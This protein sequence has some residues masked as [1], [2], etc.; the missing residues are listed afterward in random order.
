[1]EIS[2]I[3]SL[4][5]GIK[6]G[7]G[8]LEKIKDHPRRLIAVTG[9]TAKTKLPPGEGGQAE[10]DANGKP[11][12]LERTL[13]ERA[14]RGEMYRIIKRILKKRSSAATDDEGKIWN[15]RFH[16]AVEI[17]RKLRGNLD[18]LNRQYYN[19]EYMQLVG[20]EVLGEQVGIPVRR[21]SLRDKNAAADKDPTP[22]FIIGGATSGTTVTKGTAET[23][24]LQYPDR[25]VY[26][27]GYPDSKQSAITADLPEKLKEHGDLA[28]YTQINK[29]VLLRM[30]FEKFDLVGLSMGGGI[31][32]QAATDPEF[33]KKIN[34]LIAISPTSIQET[35]GKK[36]LGIDFARETFYLRRHPTQ[37]LRV[38]QVQPGSV[39]GN[40]KDMGLG[41]TGEISRHK[42]LSADDLAN[43]HIQGRV[44]I[45]TGEKDLVISC[46]QT[47][48]ETKAANENRIKKGERPIEFMEV[49]GARHGLGVVWAP[50]IAALIKNNEVLPGQVSVSQLENSTAKVL[51]RE[52]PQLAVVA[53]QILP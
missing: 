16:A 48:R 41:I 3:K 32:L 52:N 46:E 17:S 9:M 37:W 43:L 5:K 7:I 47:K 28:T 40:H 8:K 38:P 21:Y 10:Q 42:T 12:N 23:F 36:E 25:D 22:I 24:A 26:V 44:I 45:G 18:M 27:I 29:D 33:A 6:K 30:G 35:K 15:E 49:Q 11:A 39:L 14:E 13:D 31:V 34:N 50:G 4:Q 1:M 20:V 51:V 53:D 19:P 2:P